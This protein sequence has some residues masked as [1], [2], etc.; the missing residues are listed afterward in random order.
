[1]P[2]PPP[3]SPLFPYPPLSRSAPRAQPQRGF[4]RPPADGDVEVTARH[5]DL[6]GPVWLE[7]PGLAES[8]VHLFPI[9]GRER[10][11]R[12]LACRDDQYERG[13]RRDG[14]THISSEVLLGKFSHDTLVI[15]K[16]FV[17]EVTSTCRSPLRP[18][19][20][21]SSTRSRPNPTTSGS[22]WGAGCNVSARS[23]SRTRSTCSPGRTRRS[24]TSNGRAGRSWPAAGRPQSARPTSWMASPTPRSSVCFA[25]LGTWTTATSWRTRNV[26]ERRCRVVAD[27]GG[28]TV[29]ARSQP[30]STG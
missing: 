17:W 27:A 14:L 21:C 16:R 7:R 28:L 13:E 30:T 8:R 15:V 12:L 11:L 9:D 19:G 6:V 23:R 5:P 18:A 25:P 1:M 22:R 29:R 26:C 10:L 4:P 2:R 3:R 20:Y 24:K